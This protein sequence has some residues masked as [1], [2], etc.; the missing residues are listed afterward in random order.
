MLGVEGVET[1]SGTDLRI[2]RATHTAITAH[3]NR[4]LRTIKMGICE[5]GLI[6]FVKSTD[7]VFQNAFLQSWEF[8][9]SELFRK[10]G[11]LLLFTADEI[12][13]AAPD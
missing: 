9:I 13:E 4:V 11:I 1:K 7:G 3:S 10:L 5:N 12:R 2:S 6:I 8:C